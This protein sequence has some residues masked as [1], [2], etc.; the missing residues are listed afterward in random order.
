M[1]SKR[2]VVLDEQDYKSLVDQAKCRRKE[3]TADEKITSE[4]S[5]ETEPVDKS[6]TPQPEEPPPEEAEVEPPRKKPTESAVE[7]PKETTG[8]DN[9][10]KSVPQVAYPEARELL[11]L[12]DN[13]E[14]FGYDAVSGEIKLDGVPLKKYDIFKLL[15][16][17]SRKSAPNDLPVPL[18][19][20]LWKHRV[21]KFRN[22]NIR[23]RPSAEWESMFD[24]DGSTTK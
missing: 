15:A 17:T 20:F 11:E 4:K 12:L 8:D 13:L 18:R 19:L 24:S 7:K 10:L 23:L 14:S 3:P 21:T 1:S 6:E 22:R 9:L 2:L 16:A 5:T